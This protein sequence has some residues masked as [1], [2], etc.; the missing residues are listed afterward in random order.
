[1]DVNLK[2]F[3]NFSD[4]FSFLSRS[5]KLDKEGFVLAEKLLRKLVEI[6]VFLPLS[7]REKEKGRDKERDRMSKIKNFIEDFLD[8]G[9]RRL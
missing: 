4:D 1:M 2:F 8:L 5:S 6:S 3:T 9:K 7:K